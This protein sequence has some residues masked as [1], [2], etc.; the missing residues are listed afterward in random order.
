VHP[1]DFIASISTSSGALIDRRFVFIFNLALHVP[2]DA[3]ER[4][5]I[6]GNFSCC[7]SYPSQNISAVNLIWSWLK[8]ISHPLHFQFVCGLFYCLMFLL[9]RKGFGEIS[10]ND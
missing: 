1:W 8:N 3:Y 4:P 2:S 10:V 5:R 9:E 7:L 6:N